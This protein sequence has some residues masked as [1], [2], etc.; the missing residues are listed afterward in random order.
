MAPRDLRERTRLFALAVQ[1]FCRGLPGTDEAREAA[2]QLRRAATSARSN[3]RA[4]RNGRSRAEFVAKLGQAFEEADEARDWLVYLQEAGIAQ[5]AALL[6][7]AVELTKIL[8]VS[9]RTARANVRQMKCLPNLPH[10]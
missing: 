7:E 9:L 6:Q 3:Y 5:D 8:A 2:S 1:A 4:A 10:T